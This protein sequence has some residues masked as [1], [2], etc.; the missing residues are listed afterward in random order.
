MVVAVFLCSVPIHT[1]FAAAVYQFGILDWTGIHALSTDGSGGLSWLLPC[2]TA[3]LLIGLALDY[4]IFLFSRVYELRKTRFNTVPA[5]V[6][7]Q[8]NTSGRYTLQCQ[9]AVCHWSCHAWNELC[10]ALALN[11]CC[12]C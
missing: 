2:S 10:A 3:F 9:E 4:D 1:G 7:V 5:I 11:K 6:E 8:Y 12:K